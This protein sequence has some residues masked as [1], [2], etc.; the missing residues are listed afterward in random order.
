VLI[1]DFKEEICRALEEYNA[2][3]KQLKD[4]MDEATRSAEAIKMDL[5]ELKNRFAVVTADDRC[6]ICERTLLTR[7]FYAFPCQHVF[8]AD[9]LI[10]LVSP[11][12]GK[13]QL[14]RLGQIQDRM[15]ALRYSTKR[16][17]TGSMSSISQ[18]D[19]SQQANAAILDTD[20]DYEDVE[21]LREELDDI[22]ASECAL[23][24][25]VMVRTIDQPFIGTE[26]HDEILSWAV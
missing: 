21:K 9:C 16:V 25:E 6:G 2:Q 15:Q 5:E 11:Q 24:G 13:F 10:K 4:S 20:K 7:Q 18:L 17:R 3:I 14:K 1:D 8:H 22:V 12:L 26:E 19:Q 23:C